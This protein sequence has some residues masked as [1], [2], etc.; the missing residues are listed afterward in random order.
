[1]SEPDLPPVGVA[2]GR[3]SGSRARPLL[4]IG[5]HKTGTTWLQRFLFSSQRSGV[6]SVASHHLVERAFVAVNPFC[7]HP[8]EARAG[9][10]PALRNA[11]ALGLV[12]VLSHER[13]SGNPHSGGYDSRAIADRLAQTFPEARVLLVIREQ[14]SMLVSV[15]K[16]Y[17]KQGGA[18]SFRDYVRPVRGALRVPLFRFDYLEYH[19]LIGYYESLFGSENL[20]VLPYEQFRAE[21]E[22]FLGRL[23]RFVCVPVPEIATDVSVNTAPSA[24][25]LAVKRHGNRL[26]VRDALNPAPPLPFPHANAAL[27]RAC[28][29]VA[30][31]APAAAHRR[32]ERRLREQADRLAGDRYVDSNRCTADLIEIDLR[33]YGYDPTGR[34][35]PAG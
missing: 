30:R 33:A 25:P 14:R 27:S 28:G 26:F 24:L 23:A 16:Q 19:R 10:E 6:S 15:Y 9:F 31:L 20:L 12:P 11:A 1:M 7:F 2:A 22:E 34:R 29:G 18:A 13:L 5:Y 32:L 21:P 17:V 8:A 3:R 35:G 4:H